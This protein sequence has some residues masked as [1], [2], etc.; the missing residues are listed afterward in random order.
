MSQ[1]VPPVLPLSR[2]QFVATTALAAT[3]AAG[4]LHEGTQDFE[5]NPVGLSAQAQETLQLGKTTADSSTIEISGP[6]DTDVELRTQTTVYSRAAGM[7]GA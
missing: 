2:R 4:C 5:A 3:A 1:D 6:E 7:G